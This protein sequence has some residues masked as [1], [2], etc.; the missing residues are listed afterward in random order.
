[1]NTY[2]KY[3][4]VYLNKE[5]NLVGQNVLIKE[6]SFGDA[7]K[8]FHKSYPNSEIKYISFIETYVSESFES[9]DIVEQ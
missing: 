6:K 8:V 4:I 3:H 1:M 2:Y 9:F 5:G 7:E